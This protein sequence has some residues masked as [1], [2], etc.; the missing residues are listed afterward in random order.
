MNQKGIIHSGIITF[1]TKPVKE[2]IVY[3][4]YGVKVLIYV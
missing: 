1:F 3:V 2:I 4:F